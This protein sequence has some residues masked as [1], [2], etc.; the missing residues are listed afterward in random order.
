MPRIQIH[1]WLSAWDDILRNVSFFNSNFERWNTSGTG[2]FS[3]SPAA[4]IG[5]TRLPQDAPILRQVPDPSSGTKSAHMEMI[6]ADGFASATNAPQPSNGS[7]ISVDT[8]VVSPTSKGTVTLASRD[9]FTFPLINP[10][11]LTTE[12]DV[13][14]MTQAVKDARTFMTSSTFTGLIAGRFGALGAAQTDEHI[15]VAARDSVASIFHPTSTACMSPKGASWGVLDPDLRVKGVSGLRVVDASV[16][17]NI[18]ACHP[19]GVIYIVAE[20]TADL[21]KDTWGI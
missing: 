7:F 21:I 17:P 2:V 1:P 12:F 4:S 19:T 10:S 5:F 15:A 3:D 6:F 8:A 11:F 9:P 13:F 18:F 20:R 16:F 14:A